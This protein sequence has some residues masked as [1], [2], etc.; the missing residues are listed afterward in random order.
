MSN[1]HAWTE[2]AAS[3]ALGALDPQEKAEFEGHLAECPICRAEVQAYEEVTGHIG[4][5]A[6]PMAAPPRLKQRVL[7]EARK[8]RPISAGSRV[9]FARY[10]SALPWFAVAASLV[11]ALGTGFF[12]MRETKARVAAENDAQDALTRLANTRIEIAQ[13]DSLVD[14]LLAPDLQTA[15]LASRG[16]PPSARLYYNTRNR[17]VV[18]AAYDLPSVPA[19]RTYQLWGIPPGQQQPVSLGTF[20]TRSDGRAI[21]LLPVQP[22]G[23]QFEQ[24]AITEEPVGGSTQPTMQPFLIG[25]WSAL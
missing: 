1:H 7:T 4:L 11:I 23:V 19:D 5:A 25:R 3:Y 17:V 6:P 8:V 24:G 15:V 12:Y 20:N 10:F 21:I 22:G 18:L 13:R 2:Y 9:T 16:R 14:A